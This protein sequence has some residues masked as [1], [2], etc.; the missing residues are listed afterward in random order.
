MWIKKRSWVAAACVIAASPF[1]STTVSAEG[2]DGSKDMV[3][4]VIKVVGCV[5][6]AGCVLGQAKDFDLPVLVVFDANK[7][8]IRGTHESGH[9]EVSPV[10]NMEHSNDHLILQGV[11]E[12]R[13]WD[14]A[15]DTKTGEMRGA[16]VGEAVS[17]L[18]SGTCTAL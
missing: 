13:G 1:V 10:K 14:I 18:V 11:E 8:V 9:K 7:K 2:V 15:I 4:A 5:E 3:C 16:V 17:I 6:D 12:G